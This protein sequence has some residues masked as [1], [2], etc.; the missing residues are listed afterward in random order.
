M[1]NTQQYDLVSF[2]LFL[3]VLVLWCVINISV[4][5]RLS[6][7]IN[8]RHVGALC[9]LPVYTLQW[10]CWPGV[11][12]SVSLTGLL[13]NDLQPIPPVQLEKTI[14][15][16]H[17]RF[18]TEPAAPFLV[19]LLGSWLA[20]PPQPANSPSPPVW[21]GLAWLQRKQNSKSEAVKASGRGKKHRVW[22]PSV[23]MTTNQVH[24]FWLHYFGNTNIKHVL[25]KS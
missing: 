24:L 9:H 2:V 3:F 12:F 7:L 15:W 22:K 6:T 10:R 1:T 13:N 18:T 11:E 5:E 23:T 20:H 25:T 17:D 8:G 21:V 16:T 4:K 19:A 14:N